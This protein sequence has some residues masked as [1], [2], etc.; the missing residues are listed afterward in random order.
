[1]EEQEEIKDFCPTENRRFS[2]PFKMRN[3]EG[4]KTGSFESK[5]RKFSK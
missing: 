4:Y 3:F 2:V 5:N 1:M